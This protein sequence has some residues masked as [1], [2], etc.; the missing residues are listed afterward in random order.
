[1]IRTSAA[2]L[3]PI[4]FLMPARELL[5]EQAPQFGPGVRVRIWGTTGGAPLK[6]NILTLDDRTLTLEVAGQ[7][8]PAV[9]QRDTITRLDVSG[10]RRSRGKGALVGAGLGLLVGVAIGLASGSDDPNT[11]LAYS[12]GDKAL[13]S[14]ILTTPLGALVGVAVPPGERWKRALLDHVK[15]SVGTRRGRGVAASVSL[16]Y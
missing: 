7:T 13:L 3:V 4:L 8:M 10:G 11:F 9:V 12:A 16:T 15:V 2:V 5:A 14:A 1:M 6:G